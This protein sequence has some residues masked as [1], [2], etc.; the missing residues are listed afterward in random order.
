MPE[1]QAQIE[2]LPAGATL[3]PLTPPPAPAQDEIEGLP[4]GAQLRPVGGDI[5]GL[6][7]GAQTQPLGT[8]EQTEPTEE[9][10]GTVKASAPGLGISRLDNSRFFW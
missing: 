2:G 7:P 3:R 10:I 1:P 4:P 9:T 5:E 6:P 8:S